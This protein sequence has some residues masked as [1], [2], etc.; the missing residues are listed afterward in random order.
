MERHALLEPLMIDTRF[1]IASLTVV[2]ALCSAVAYTNFR[3]EGGDETARAAQTFLKQLSPEQV[4]VAQLPYAAPERVD[5]H[6]IPK[7]ARKGMQVKFMNPAQRE[8]SFL[9]LRSVVSQLGYKK[10]TTIMSMEKLLYELEGGQGANIRD[11]ERYF[12]TVFGNPAGADPWGL[13]IEGHHMSLNFVLQGDQVISS[14]PQVFAANPATIK[15]K[16]ASGFEL[17]A[18]ILGREEQLAFDLV[19][20]LNAEQKAAAIFD[21]TAPKEVRNAGLAQPPTDA[22]IGISAGKLDVEQQKLLRSLLEEYCAAMPDH[23]AQARLQELDAAGFDTLHFA[24]AGATEAGIGHYYRVQGPT[25]LVEFVNTQ[26]DAAGNIANHIH[27][28]W[29]DIRG[30]FALPAK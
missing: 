2:F 27:C 29:R 19:L 5:W 16:N 17:G 8:A 20:S 13:S 14:T 11:S 23:V 9:L 15:N 4:K 7:P 21:K 1:R 12:F 26:P 18:R 25:C 22:P 24:W 28:Y 30:D 3:R 10:A 6:F